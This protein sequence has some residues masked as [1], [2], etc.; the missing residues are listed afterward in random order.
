M[1]LVKLLLVT[2]LCSAS[3][4]VTAQDATGDRKD[5]REVLKMGLYPPDIL[6]R[7]QQRLGITDNQRQS[8]AAL[9]KTF[10]NG[11][12]E[13][14]WSMPNEQQQLQQ[15]LRSHPVPAEEA[16]AQSAKVLEMES[17]FK[18]AHFELLVAIK[19]ELTKEQVNMLNSVIRRRLS[20]QE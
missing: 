4:G 20:G 3:L 8:I 6:M 5:H 11:V 12:T 1:R 15:L 9:V 2:L 19:N 7:Q 14:Q 18:Q 13:L 10:Q 16:L 17:R